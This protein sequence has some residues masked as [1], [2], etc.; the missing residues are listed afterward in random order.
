MNPQQQIQQFSKFLAYILERRP[1]E[2][3]LIPDEE[4]FVLIKDLLKAFSEIQ[5][6]RHIRA[7]H[8][9]ELMIT[10]PDAPFEFADNRIRAVKRDQLPTPEPCK[11][12]PK[13][14]Y[15]PIRRKAYPA[16]REKGLRPGKEGFIVCTADYDL[17]QQLG[18]RKDNQPVVLTIHTTKTAAQGIGF[19]IFGENLYLTQTL[20]PD[21]FTGPAMPKTPD[22]PGEGQEKDEF[23][24]YRRKAKAGTFMVDPRDLGPP[25]EIKKPGKGKKK[26]LSWKQER[27][28]KRRR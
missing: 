23:A 15:T 24:E 19:N 2:F 10:S 12:L 1:D 5:G 20:P 22:Q 26:Q 8:F 3:C 11:N 14:L 4:G 27:K 7:S 18:R 6:W 28:E 21:T 16:V 25:P 13:L 17:A 9:N